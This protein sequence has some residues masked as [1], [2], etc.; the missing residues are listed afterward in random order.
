MAP[1]ADSETIKRTISR[2][3]RVLLINTDGGAG[4]PHLQEQV[5]GLPSQLSQERWPVSYTHL[6]AH[7]TGAYL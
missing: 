1:G 4:G 7:E 6:R 2:V 3:A 5:G